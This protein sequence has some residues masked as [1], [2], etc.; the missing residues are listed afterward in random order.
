MVIAEWKPRVLFVVSSLGF[1]GSER[2]FARIINASKEAIEPIVLVFDANIKQPVHSKV[3]FAPSV[4]IHGV[5]SGFRAT[6][7]RAV[8]LRALI[9]KT[10]PD[11]VISTQTTVNL[12]L[13]VAMALGFFRFAKHCI[14]RTAYNPFETFMVSREAGYRLLAILE[15]LLAASFSYVGYVM[16][17]SVSLKRRFQDET[18]IRFAHSFAI[19]NFCDR[20]EIVRLSAERVENWPEVPVIVSVGRLDAEKNPLLLVRAFAAVRSRI[21]CKLAF[22]GWGQL[23][24]R[25][26]SL[27]ESLGVSDDVMFLGEQQNPFKFMAKARLFALSSDTDAMP[28]ALIEAMAIGLPVV[29]TDCE[30]CREILGDEEPAGLVVPRRNPERLAQAIVGLLTDT[31]ECSRYSSLSLARSQAFDS[32]KAI[33]NY[34][35]LFRRAGSN[36]E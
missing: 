18:P 16:F 29:T 6:M 26:R 11:V 36:I 27:A 15:A 7:R 32:K 8:A 20:E 14:L 30:G 10:R 12:V 31:E 17:P 25:C 21:V 4:E 35:A 22:V 19:R 1:G 13:A 2:V 3:Y 24:E 23:Q 9:S 5:A 34:V 33:T 28:N